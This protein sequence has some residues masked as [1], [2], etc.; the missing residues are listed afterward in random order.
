MRA[1]VPQGRVSSLADA[2]RALRP[3]LS[4][5]G[6][7]LGLA[8]TEE[9]ALLPGG[10]A[11]RGLAR[12]MGAAR[13]Q[14]FLAGRWALR[15]ALDAVGCPAP[16]ISYEGRR[17]KVP[18]RTV[19]SLTHSGGTAV[20][21]AARRDTCRTVGVDLELHQLPLEAAHLVLTPR[22]AGW[23]EA[24]AAG[25]PAAARRLL[26]TVFSA[27]EAVF[28]A[29]AAL[30]GGAASPRTLRDIAVRPVPHGFEAWQHGQAGPVLRTRVRWVAGAVLCWT[31]LPAAG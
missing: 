3:L 18:D 25:D 20:A 4:A 12:C 24:T 22:E 30:P 8:G 27:K 15:R 14:E 5:Q 28:K 2:V 10:P 31:V 6:L 9:T 29:L 23:L 11:E 26:H 19:A 7:A 17:P 1:P 13:R 21:L 16:D